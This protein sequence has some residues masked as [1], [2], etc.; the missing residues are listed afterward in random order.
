MRTTALTLSG[1]LGAASAVPWFLHR[2]RLLNLV[3]WI[4]RIDA[5]TITMVLWGPPELLDAM[6]VACSLGPANV[7]VEDFVRTR[8]DFDGPP[9]T[10]E[11]RQAS[12]SA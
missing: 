11:I 6:E 1:D 8:H 4:S 2:G 12:T 3:G 5:R 10:F 7:I 9:A